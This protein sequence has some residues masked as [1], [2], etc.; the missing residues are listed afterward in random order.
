MNCLDSKISWNKSFFN[1]HDSY[2]GRHVNAASHKSLE[3]K[4]Y[5]ITNPRTLLK[6]KFV[7]KLV[8]SCSN[9]S[10]KQNLGRIDS[11]LV[12]ILAGR[13]VKTNNT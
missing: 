13:H 6:L 7:W 5:S 9:A 4:A 10:W 2:L 12:W 8:F 11:F 3:I 1:L